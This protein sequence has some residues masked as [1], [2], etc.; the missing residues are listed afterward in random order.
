[1]TN[2]ELLLRTDVYEE[3]D[4]L[5]GLLLEYDK[6]FP[7]NTQKFRNPLTE[8]GVGMVSL[9][10][11]AFITYFCALTPKYA[12]I[13]VLFHAGYGQI[14]EERRLAP[15]YHPRQQDIDWIDAHLQNLQRHP[16]PRA[17][18]RIITYRFDKLENLL[19]L[20]LNKEVH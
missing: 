14:P 11:P 15:D 3:Y 9:P 19:G 8:F 16:D 13:S 5:Y 18:G 2:P 20:M 17:G 10:D 12:L 4:A 6:P 7:F 1:M